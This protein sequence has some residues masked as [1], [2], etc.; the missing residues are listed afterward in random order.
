MHVTRCKATIY[1]T[2]PTLGRSGESK[3]VETVERSVVVGVQ[4]RRMNRQITNGFQGSE[5]LCV[6]L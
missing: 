4:G 1:C 6:I 5:I 2:I 3:T